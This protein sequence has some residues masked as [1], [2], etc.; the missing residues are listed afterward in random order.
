MISFIK[1]LKQYLKY[2]KIKYLKRSSKALLNLFKN[3]PKTYLKIK[4]FSLR[5]I[6]S[7]INKHLKTISK[8]TSECESVFET[9]VRGV[10]SSWAILNGLEKNKSTS[11]NFLM[12]DIEII[13]INEIIK[14]A[15]KIGIDLSHEWIDNLKLN[16]NNN[17]DMTFIDTW[18]VYA[19]LKRELNLF[20]K[21]TNKFIVL[22]DTTVDGELGESV[23]QGYDIKKQSIESGFTEDEISKGLWPAVEEF[24]EGNSDWELMKRFTHNNGLTILKK[25]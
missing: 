11:K 8:L 2:I 22:H 15:K 7:D 24:L 4:Y 6:P 17:Y 3:F 20:S 23:R 25:V 1:V 5:L 12:N 21:I 9:G 19:Q 14:I 18:H 13:D 16:L 10:V